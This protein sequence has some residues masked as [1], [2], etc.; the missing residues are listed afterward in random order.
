V[1]TE[2]KQT[3]DMKIPATARSRLRIQFSLPRVG[4]HTE[5]LVDLPDGWSPVPTWGPLIVR[6]RR[7]VLLGKPATFTGP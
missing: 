6:I 3:G 2:G 7:G 4:R 1:C 5:L